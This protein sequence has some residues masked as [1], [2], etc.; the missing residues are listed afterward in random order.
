MF[1][2]FS[3]ISK[4]K[5]WSMKKSSIFWQSYLTLEKEALE[6]SKYIFFTD[7]IPIKKDGIIISQSYDTHLNVFSPHIADLL[8]RCCIQIEAISKELYFDNGG[9]KTRDDSSIL[10]DSDCLKLLDIKWKIHNKS[11]IIIAPSFNFVKDENRILKPLKNAHKSQGT[12]WERAYQAVKHD[13]YMSLYMGTVKAFLQAL[14]A[15]YLLN[16]YYR[17]DTFITS[18]RCV[19]ELDYSF[20]SL[21]F[22]VTPPT[23]KEPW[24]DNTPINSDSPYVA[25]YQDTAYQYIKNLQLKESQRLIA[26]L[27]MQSETNEPAFQEQLNRAFE[28]EKTDPSKKVILIWEL[29]KYRLNKRIPNTL[30]FAER[31]ALLIESD[32]WK[33]INHQNNNPLSPDK[34]TEDTIQHEI[35]SAG[36]HYGMNMMNSLQNLEWVSFANNSET[37]MVYIS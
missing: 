11:V 17:N 25:T 18:Y 6:L 3:I 32:E 27:K 2:P 23:V 13:R 31:K 33:C 8:I 28:R 7:E 14:A 30:S 24:Y 34:I 36:I 21:I 22:A 19:S 37:F 29:A 9:Q 26:Y 4:E 1:F 20:G 5:I 35:D 15:L 16:L 12:Y 10:F